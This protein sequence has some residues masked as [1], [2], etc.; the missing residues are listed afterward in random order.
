MLLVV[1]LEDVEIDGQAVRFPE[2]IEHI[3]IAGLNVLGGDAQAPSQL[4]PE[5]ECIVDAATVVLVVL[6]QQLGPS[7]KRLP[8]G[9]P[10]ERQRP[11]RQF[12][13]RIPLALPDL[14]YAAGGETVTQPAQQHPGTLALVWPERGGIPLC[15]FH[16]V[17]RD[18]GGLATQGQAH[19]PGTQLLVHRPPQEVDGLP[20]VLRIRLGD[21]RVF[22]DALHGIVMFEGHHGVGIAPEAPR[23]RGGAHRI[24]CT[25]EWNVPLARKQTRGGVQT[26][27]AGAGHVDLAPGVQIGEIRLRAG[28]P[29][30]GFHIRSKLH[31]VAGHETRRQP[32]VPHDLHQ[33]PG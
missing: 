30:E 7:P 2:V 13:P 29:V 24:G 26:D 27:P 21:P 4:A 3:L 31:E 32:H 17:D 9:S 22:M 8:V 25:G 18:E 5:A 6:G 12:L 19:V 15:R 10:K 16:V 14:K 23:N 28:W 11:A 20:L 1:Q 33:Q